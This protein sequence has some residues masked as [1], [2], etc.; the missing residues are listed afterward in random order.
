MNEYQV[1]LSFGR[2]YYLSS[3]KGPVILF[4]HGGVAT[5]HA[6]IPLFE[7]LA[8]DYTVV[9]P[10]HP[11]HGK[12]FSI[13]KSWT[14]DNYITVYREFLDKIL[15]TPDIII[16]HSFGV[17]L[18]LL[19]GPLF[20]SARIIVFDSAGLPLNLTAKEYIHFMFE[21]G[22]ALLAKR[23][24]LATIGETVP[25]VGSLVSTI[26]RHPEDLPWLA[27]NVLT[28]DISEK[29]RHI[30]NKVS[31]IWG[32]FDAIVKPECGRQMQQIIPNADLQIVPKKGHTY[33][34]MDIE[35]A[36]KLIINSINDTSKN[37]I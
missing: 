19:L 24:D 7:K 6:Y 29:L 28:M 16:G 34:A 8:S 18:A 17:A 4:L 37:K 32:Q 15:I 31:L 36:Y 5:A 11:G 12:S 33:P 20:R 30:S 26:V 22:T 21:E 1:D 23:P 10:T 14:V 3:G 13:G 25:K 9:A 27:D 2:I 35:L